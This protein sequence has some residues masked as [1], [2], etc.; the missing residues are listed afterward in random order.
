VLDRKHGRGPATPLGD[1]L[2][3]SVIAPDRRRRPFAIR[4][5]DDNAS[6]DLTERRLVVDGPSVAEMRKLLA[7]K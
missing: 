2:C 6:L 1:F 7:Q 4:Q 3:G 5:R